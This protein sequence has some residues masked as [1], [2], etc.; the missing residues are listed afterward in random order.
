MYKRQAWINVIEDLSGLEITEEGWTKLEELP[1][2]IF[3]LLN[4]V[5]RGYVPALLTNKAAHEK[6]EKTWEAEIDGCP[7]VQQTFPYQSK[8]LKWINEEY[9]K[10]SEMDRSRID[11]VL[12]D[13]GCEKLFL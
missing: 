6:G 1:E 2:S 8:C 11:N 9:L 7:W 12:K 4:E 13:T 5:G 3:D 10:L